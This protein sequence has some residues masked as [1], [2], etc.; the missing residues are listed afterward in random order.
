MAE[1]I[2]CIPPKIMQTSLLGRLQ[3]T[4]LEHND[5]WYEMSVSEGRVR[6]PPTDNAPSPQNYF[7][8]IVKMLS[9][10]F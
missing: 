10:C 9:Q 4:L 2:S 6:K 7:Q 5:F 1:I 3:K 8:Q